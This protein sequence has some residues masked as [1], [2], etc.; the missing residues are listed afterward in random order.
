MN[1]AI[2]FRYD[3]KKNPQGAFLAGVPLRDLTTAEFEELPEWLQR[4]V[5]ATDFYVEVK[6]ATKTAVK[7]L[8]DGE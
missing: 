3:E 8:K 6:V 4:S 1:D 2:A 5:K 7:P